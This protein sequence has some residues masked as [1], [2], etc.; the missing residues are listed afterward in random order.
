MARCEVVPHFLEFTAGAESD[1]NLKPLLKQVC[2][3]E[4]TTHSGQG[5]CVLPSCSPAV[6]AVLPQPAAGFV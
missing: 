1:W 2:G 4:T 3:R 6:N 5:S